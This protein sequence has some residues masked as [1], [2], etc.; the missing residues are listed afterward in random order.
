MRVNGQKIKSVLAVL[1]AVFLVSACGGIGS[2]SSAM[3][4]VGMQDPIAQFPDQ[5]PDM[6]ADGN[7]IDPVTP[8]PAVEPPPPAVASYSYSGTGN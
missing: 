5:I 4:G 7:W 1:V 2:A 8:P 6:D 3:P